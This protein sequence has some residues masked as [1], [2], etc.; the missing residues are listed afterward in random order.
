[1]LIEENGSPVLTLLSLLTVSGQVNILG[2][3]GGNQQALLLLSLGFNQD[4]SLAW[5]GREP[6]A[7]GGKMYEGQQPYTGVFDKGGIPALWLYVFD[8]Q[9]GFGAVQVSFSSSEISWRF[10]SYLNQGTLPRVDVT[11]TATATGNILPDALFDHWE[12]RAY[13]TSLT[14]GKKSRIIYRPFDGA[15]RLYEPYGISPYDTYI[16][17]SV[18]A[19]GDYAYLR[20]GE[21]EGKEITISLAPENVVDLWLDTSRGAIDGERDDAI[22]RVSGGGKSTEIQIALFCEKLDHFRVAASPE[23]IDHGTTST[24]TVIAEDANNQEVIPESDFDVTFTLSSPDVFEGSIRDTSKAGGHLPRGPMP[25]LKKSVNSAE[26]LDGDIPLYGSFSIDGGAPQPYT[27]TVPYALAKEGKV[28]YVADGQIPFGEAPEPVTV[29]VKKADNES[30]SGS[31]DVLVKRTVVDR[32]TV[33][34]SKDTIVEGESTTIGITAYDANNN[35]ITA[36]LAGTSP[37]LFSLDFAG[38]TIGALEGPTGKANS[39][40][41]VVEDVRLGRLSFLANPPAPPPVATRIATGTNRETVKGKLDNAI[42]T[43]L[44]TAFMSQKSGEKKVEVEK[45][46]VP[47]VLIVTADPRQLEHGAVSVVKVQPVDKKGNAVR[48]ASDTKI[49]FFL[50]ESELHGNLAGGNASGRFLSQVSYTDVQKGKVHF[51]ANG[52]Q[53]TGL[54][55]YAVAVGATAEMDSRMIGGVGLA[56]INSTNN[57][58]AQYF[59]QGQSPWGD[60]P[61]DS[62]D[63]TISGAGCALTALA[64]TLKASEVSTDPGVLN[65][66]MNDNGYY[67]VD[68]GVDWGVLNE[69]GSSLFKY[70]GTQRGSG[71]STGKGESSPT[72]SLSEMDSHL[73]R[74]SAIIAQVYNPTTKRQHWVLVTGKEGSEYRILDPGG[75]GRST[76]GGDY[77]SRVYRFIVFERK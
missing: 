67:T 1:M 56:I 5:K 14:C 31:V 11:A 2:N 34:S 49:N 6:I 18:E 53:V 46:I 54:W 63:A 4:H 64:L 51:A 69:F 30:K 38:S 41:V 17:V 74:G 43:A 66:F 8:G 50:D 42:G 35:D 23:E 75:Y 10:T 20:C 77:E 76:L 40:A 25:L 70:S 26:K 36:S 22:V 45:R 16:T 68:G 32:I 73:S 55:P 65:T 28:R 58:G 71:I 59:S 13:P 7:W 48:I 24:L 57:S 44:I 72:V 37:V 33:S 39:L 9:S 61:Y 29:T 12:I 52:D 47:E 62:I 19:K 60:D 3:I 27:V 21:Q 15:K